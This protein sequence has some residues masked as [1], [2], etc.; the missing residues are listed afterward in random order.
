MDPRTETVCLAF[1]WHHD[2]QGS[3]ANTVEEI[4]R[5]ANVDY[6]YH[7]K[8]SEWL[9]Y[10]FTNDAEVE[11][12]IKRIK[13]VYEKIARADFLIAHLEYI[14]PEGAINEAWPEPEVVWA[15][16]CAY[17]HSTMVLGYYTKKPNTVP[18]IL[19]ASI[20][21]YLIGPEQLKAFVKGYDRKIPKFNWEETY[22]WIQTK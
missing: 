17:T 20:H 8:W 16:G 14:T 12:G 1:P 2:A 3:A 22:K 10:Y 11:T 9:Q 5:D 15:V 19:H 18:A 7:G 13:E 6:F 4:L 21:G